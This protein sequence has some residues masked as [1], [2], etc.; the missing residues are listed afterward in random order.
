MN[1]T[2]SPVIQRIVG[3]RHDNDLLWLGALLAVAMLACA[4]TVRAEP[5]SFDELYRGVSECRFDLSRFNGIPMEPYTE[6]VLIGLPQG[7]AVQGFL[8]NAFYFSP[9]R[10]GKGEDYG[11]VFNAPLEAVARALPQLAGRETVNGYLRSLSTGDRS[12]RSKTLLHCSAGR[13]T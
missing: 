6:A 10:N 7:G 9:A 1:P 3:T 5:P 4:G 12:A 11:L 2:V 13:Q 8:I